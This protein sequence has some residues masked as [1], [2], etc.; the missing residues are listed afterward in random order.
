MNTKFFETKERHINFRKAFADMTINGT[1]RA[2]HFL[3]F[4]I[5]RQYPATR[6]FSPVTRQIRLDN[7]HYPYNALYDAARQ[8]TY[9]QRDAKEMLAH[10]Q[11]TLISKNISELNS[12]D[13]MLLKCQS[14]RLE[15]F[16]KPF[17]GALTFEDI[18][19]VQI[20]KIDLTLGVQ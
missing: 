14:T 6:G 10:G 7:G 18:L 8:L 9:I 1:L 19:K 17:N 20:P 12:K 13:K 3:L 16:I 2:E 4:N 11:K 15:R 5:I